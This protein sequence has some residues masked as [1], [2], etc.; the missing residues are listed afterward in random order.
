MIEFY[1]DL[2]VHI[3]CDSLGRPIK[4]SGSRKMTFEN[5]EMEFF[6]RIGVDIV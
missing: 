5:I 2:H 3:G 1:V 6:F 4:V